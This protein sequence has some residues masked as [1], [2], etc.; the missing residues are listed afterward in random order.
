[1]KDKP[2]IQHGQDLVNQV[3]TTGVELEEVSGRD[4]MRKKDN[5]LHLVLL[6]FL[7]VDAGEEHEWGRGWQ[8]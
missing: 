3:V 6:C 2:N 5:L 7:S 8:Q 4:R 1:M